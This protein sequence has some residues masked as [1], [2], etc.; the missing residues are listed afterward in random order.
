M[1]PRLVG[2]Y[3]PGI[4]RVMACPDRII[5]ELRSGE[6]RRLAG[7]WSLSKGMELN[8]CPKTSALIRI[9]RTW[10]SAV[11]HER[12]RARKDKAL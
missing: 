6:F 4:R 9:Q 3:Q 1:Q 2:R 5:L 8:E 12:M 7:W 10:R 11:S